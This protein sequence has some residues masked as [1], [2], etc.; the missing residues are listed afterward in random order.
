MKIV[1]SS[2]SIPQYKIYFKRVAISEDIVNSFVLLRHPVLHTLTY[3]FAS[4][5]RNM[6]V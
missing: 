4:Y 5:T 3:I 6:S 1:K 2:N